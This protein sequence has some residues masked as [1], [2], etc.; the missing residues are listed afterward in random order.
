[1]IIVLFINTFIQCTEHESTI[2]TTT[3]SNETITSVQTK[4]PPTTTTTTAK[5]RLSMEEKMKAMKSGNMNSTFSNKSLIVPPNKLFREYLRCRQ[6][7]S[8][9][10]LPSPSACP[11]DYEDNIRVCWRATAN[12]TLATNIIEYDHG[13]NNFY[14]G[15]RY[16][17]ENCTLERFCMNNGSW[18]PTISPDLQCKLCVG[19]GRP[20]KFNSIS[21]MIETMSLSLSLLSLTIAVLC[22]INVKRLHL[23][24]NLLH[25]HL[26]VA[27][28]FRSIV[29]LVFIHLIIGGYTRSMVSYTQDKC[30]MI[31]IVSK[32]SSLF[33]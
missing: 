21:I 24:R 4:L 33:H 12:G 32:S 10:K 20:V 3:T 17:I 18:A 28:I 19:D 25:M 9:N 27:F 13:Q 6:L 23:P 15:V 1:M 2:Q 7:S 30:G 11:Y 22:M 14:D 5:V 29:K 8:L 26:F 31:E 16:G